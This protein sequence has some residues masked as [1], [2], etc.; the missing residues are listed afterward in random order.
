M[1]GSHRLLCGEGM[2][3]SMLQHRGRAAAH[4]KVGAGQWLETCDVGQGG[5]SCVGRGEALTM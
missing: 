2:I 3:Q 1:S 5:G 4:G